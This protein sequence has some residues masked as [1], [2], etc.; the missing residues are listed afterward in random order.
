MSA[1]LVLCTLFVII[2]KGF[3]IKK[4]SKQKARVYS[5]CSVGRVSFVEEVF[6]IN[7]FRPNGIEC[8]LQFCAGFDGK[9]LLLR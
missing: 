3:C 9:R 6:A 5:K 4:K 8:D 1:C 7:P 2:N